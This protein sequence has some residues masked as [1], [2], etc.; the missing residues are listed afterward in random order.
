MTVTRLNTLT[1]THMDDF[2]FRAMLGGIGVALVAGPMGCVV[3]WRRMAYF[4][5][6]LAHAALL[7]IALGFLLDV[8]LTFGVLAVCLLLALTL[9]ALEGRFSLSNDTLLGI[10]AHSMLAMGLLTLAMMQDLRVDLLGYLFGDVLAI[11]KHDVYLIFAVT[12]GSV[13]VLGFYWRALIAVTINEEVASVEGIKVRQVRLAFVLLLATVIAIGMKVIGILLIVSLL[14]IP[15]AAARVV[16]RTPEQMAVGSVVVGVVAVVAG[17]L[18]SLQWDLPAG[19][20][21]VVWATLAFV[22]GLL[23]LRF[24][25]SKAKIA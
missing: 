22:A 25:K 21:I 18:S 23:W 13:I 5:A 11:S 24:G 4:G 9:S 2:F 8:N 15:A 1:P 6:A 20:A 12:L 14:I 16:S 17:L 7:G 3:V 19:P 10:M